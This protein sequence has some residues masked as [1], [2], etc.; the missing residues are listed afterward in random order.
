MWRRLVTGTCTA[1]DFCVPGRLCV[2]EAFAVVTLWVVRVACVAEEFALMGFWDACGVSVDT[3]FEM[4][5]FLAVVDE[6]F[7]VV[8]F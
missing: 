3:V 4:G 8:G 1:V 6:P 2:N 7:A 5:D